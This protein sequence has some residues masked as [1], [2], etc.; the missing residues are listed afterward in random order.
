[1]HALLG[2]LASVLLVAGLA[3]AADEK[4]A[5]PTQTQRMT[6]CNARAADKHL[7][8]DA[9]KEFMSECLKAA[10]EDGVK[11]GKDP[12]PG[13]PADGERHSTQGEKM[14]ACNQE[15][16]AKNLRGDE[17]RQFMSGCLK[18]EKKS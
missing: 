16:S 6:E 13:K 12:R 8:G 4:T 15:A 9:R 14:K 17:R 2:A 11:A 10:H 1:M 5:R 18:A 3:S 7:A